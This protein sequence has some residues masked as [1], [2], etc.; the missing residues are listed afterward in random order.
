MLPRSMLFSSRE[1]RKKIE[2]ESRYGMIET[3]YK[4]NTPLRIASREDRMVQRDERRSQI[5]KEKEIED[6]KACE[7]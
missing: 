6:S 7:T 1:E 5:L 2:E 4:D 3:G